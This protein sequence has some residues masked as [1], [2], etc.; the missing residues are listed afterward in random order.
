MISSIF[1]EFEIL[2][3]N[4]VNND[5]DVIFNE[6]KFFDTYETVD[7]FKKEQRKFYVT[8]RVISLQIFEN[9]DEKQ[10]NKILIQKYVLN[11]SWKNVISKLIMKKNL[12]I[13]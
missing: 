3:K 11:N 5:R 9:I 12:I 2:K 10:Y 6:T 7:F 13:N 1:F 8:Y 4:D